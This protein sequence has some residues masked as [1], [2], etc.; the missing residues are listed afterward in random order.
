MDDVVSRL[1]GFFFMSCFNKLM[2][3]DIENWFVDSGYFH[4]VTRS[5]RVVFLNFTE[6]DFDCYVGLG[7][8][9]R[10]E[11]KGIGIVRF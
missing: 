3:E 2:Y 8:K 4:H 11:V 6:I 5:L 10:H 1:E 9:T 7:T